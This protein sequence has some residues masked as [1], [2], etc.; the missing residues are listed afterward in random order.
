MRFLF[1]FSALLLACCLPVGVQAQKFSNE[2]LAIGSSA[3]GLAMS[4]TQAAIVTDVTAGYW[5][6]A[7]LARMEGKYQASAMHA[8]YFAGI[9]NYDYLAGAVKLDNDNALALTIIR[10]AVDDIPDTRFLFDAD[11]A[12][13]FENVRAF[14]AADYA[15]LLSY[16]KDP[17][18]VKGLTLGGSFKLIH[19]TVGP[20]AQAW[21]FGLDVGAQW[22]QGP[23]QI[24]LAARDITGTFNNWSFNTDEFE[25][26]FLQTGNEVPTETL[27]VTVPRTLLEVGYQWR[28]QT[29]RFGVLG[30]LGAA[31]TFDG[32]RNT[33][34]SGELLSADPS[35]GLEADFR[36]RFFL[37]G[38]IGNF[39][40]V[41]TLDG[42]QQWTSQANF[43][44]GIAL[45]AFRIDYALTDVGDGSDALYSHVFSLTMQFGELTTPLPRYTPQ[46]N[47]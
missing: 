13:N 41:P 14:S 40:Q 44:L 38:G 37:R 34:L 4:N 10:F 28:D 32:Q 29:D 22:H 11:G 6:P 8:E 35:A 21:G 23:W 47:R 43:G 9:A 7:G 42:S 3:R 30:T 24:G 2:F 16:A 20:F 33:L 36:R 26:I 12:V 15:V 1:F 18:W 45:S 5:N 19:R 25:D 27:E 46:Y 39:Q 17:G 31:L